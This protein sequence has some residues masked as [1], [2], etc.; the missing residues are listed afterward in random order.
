MRISILTVIVSVVFFVAGLCGAS[1]TV[2]KFELTAFTLEEMDLGV[3]CMSSFPCP[4]R[5]GLG[6]HFFIESNDG[7]IKAH[8]RT[9]L[10]RKVRIVV[11]EVQQ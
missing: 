8:M 5:W 7:S 2:K 1:E 4:A 6:S 9:L 10:H 3:Q 11:Y